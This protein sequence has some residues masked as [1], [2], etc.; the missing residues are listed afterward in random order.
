MKALVVLMLVA[1]CHGGGLFDRDRLA[2]VVEAVRPRVT[3]VG[4]HYRF[5]LD[6]ALDASS[7]ARVAPDTMMGRGDGRGRV[8]A[9]VSADRKLAV[10]IETED[11]GHAGEDGF[12]Y[13]DEGFPPR[14]L[15]GT[16]LD[17]QHETRIDDRWVRWNF[18]MD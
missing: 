18:D 15:E 12:M 17:S 1:G 5:Q 14:E 16:Q 8:R 10:S 13:V 2:R 7:L 11:Y 3:I 6:D 9:V 4:E